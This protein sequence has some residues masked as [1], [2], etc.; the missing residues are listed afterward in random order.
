MEWRERNIISKSLLSYKVEG[1]KKKIL[2]KADW[3]SGWRLEVAA[4]GIGSGV[5]D[6][7]VS[8]GVTDSCGGA[9]NRRVFLLAWIVF[10][11][12]LLNSPRGPYHSCVS[13][14]VQK[15]AQLINTN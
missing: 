8:G 7:W 12:N 1:E 9:A 6:A 14:L 2:D 10:V 11:E 15:A 5:H 3:D 13:R 4:A